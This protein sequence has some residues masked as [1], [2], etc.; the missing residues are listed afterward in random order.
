ME[1]FKQLCQQVK[2]NRIS[3][4]DFDKEFLEKQCNNAVQSDLANSKTV[5]VYD[6]MDLEV[7]VVYLLSEIS[8]MI[9]Q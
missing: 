9:L 5:V 6:D 3:F 7:N 8:T 4:P 1:N 2:I